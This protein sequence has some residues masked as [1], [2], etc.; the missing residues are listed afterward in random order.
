MQ[1]RPQCGACCIAPSISTT[2]PGMPNG[3]AADIRCIQL[4]E[5]YACKVFSQP[6]RP[7]VCTMF[8]A[9]E[10]VCG[11]NRQQ[12]LLNLKNLENLTK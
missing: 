3:K 11:E 12:A 10:D 9:C 5:N 1:C 4:D 2:I 8:K 7:S 6:E